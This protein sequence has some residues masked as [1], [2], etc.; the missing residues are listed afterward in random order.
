MAGTVVPV[1]SLT[2]SSSYSPH[3]KSLP[4]KR[5]VSESLC[6]KMRQAGDSMSSARMRMRNISSVPIPIID[7]NKA[8]TF[9]GC[10][11]PYKHVDTHLELFSTDDKTY[12]GRSPRL[13][14]TCE[15]SGWRG[16]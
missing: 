3:I 16:V 13:Q 8:L 2:L 5:T 10:V 9:G 6:S 11:L 4:K 14:T 15:T 1:S 12:G 7:L